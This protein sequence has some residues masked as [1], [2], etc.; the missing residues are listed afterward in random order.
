MAQPRAHPTP[1]AAIPRSSFFSSWISSREP[2][3]QLEL[4]FRRRTVHLRR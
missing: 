1:A 4:Q 2:G 3:R